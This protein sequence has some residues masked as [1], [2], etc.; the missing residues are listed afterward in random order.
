MFTA[1]QSTTGSNQADITGLIGQY[2][3]GNEPSHHFA[4]LY[5]YAGAPHKTQQRVR[6][7]LTTLFQPTPD[8]LPGNE[9]C[10]Q[11]SAWFVM[12]ALGLYPVT[13]GTTQYAITSP[14]F[15]RATL[16]LES[17]PFTM[18]TSGNGPYVAS[19]TLNGGGYNLLTLDHADLAARGELTFQ[20]TSHPSDW[21]NG[22]NVPIVDDDSFVEAP[23]VVQGERSFRGEQTVAL[24]NPNGRGAIVYRLVHENLSPGPW[25]EYHEPFLIDA[26]TTLLTKVRYPVVP[27]HRA[28]I[29][30]RIS[31]VT[32]AEFIQ[33]PNNWTITLDAEYAPQYAAEGQDALID[34]IRGDE[35]WRKGDWQGF[36]DQDVVATIDLGEIQPIT[37]IYASFLQDTGPWII[38]PREVIFEV[39]EDGEVFEE[40][41]RAE[42]PQPPDSLEATTSVY[43]GGIGDVLVLARYVRMRAVT[44]GSLPDWHLGAGNPSWVFVDEMWAE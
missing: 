12:S 35:E 19:A 44:Y 11:M 24:Y 39:S 20:L 25:L 3:Q 4:Y 13:P 14:L 31:A 10:G 8:G 37:Y 1:P 30:A 27:H 5:N 28:R 36:Y 41:L 29:R 23:L 18:S 17:G 21:G 38:F 33:R 34:G 6:Q 32:R 43:G 16:N 9:D 22:F 26:T 42:A 7:I 40:F 15:E 2:A